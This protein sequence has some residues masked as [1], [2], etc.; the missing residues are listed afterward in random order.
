MHVRWYEA[1]I[2]KNLAPAKTRQILFGYCTFDTECFMLHTWQPL[3]LYC[4]ISV[5]G[6][7]GNSIR[8]EW[9]IQ[10]GWL[11]GVTLSTTCAVYI[12]IIDYEGLVVVQQ[13][14]S[15]V[16]WKL[17]HEILGSIPWVIMPKLLH[18]LFAQ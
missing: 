5:R 12:Y 13:L 4:Q 2:G 11:P 17:K 18:A 7:Q 14:Y 8:K 1:K 6:Q 15:S 10:L 16:Y 9:L 3:G